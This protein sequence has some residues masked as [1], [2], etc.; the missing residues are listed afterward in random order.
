MATARPLAA[1][2]PTCRTTSPNLNK[3]ARIR[4]RPDK[5][6]DRDRLKVGESAGASAN[7]GKPL[8]S[9]EASSRGGHLLEAGASARA[10]PV[11]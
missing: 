1:R 7:R 11:T 2:P 6:E 4:R 9:A 5:D 10:R 8:A 3:D